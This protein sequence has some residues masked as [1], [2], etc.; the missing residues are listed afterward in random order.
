MKKLL[1]T[2]ESECIGPIRALVEKQNHRTLVLWALD[3]APTILEIF[4]R[5]FPNDKRPKEAL[6]A[7]DDWARGEIKMPV[8][9]KAIH[10]AHNA[11]SGAEGQMAAQAAARAAGHAAATVH[12]ETH[13]LSMVFYGLTA[14]VYDGEET[15]KEAIVEEK[16]AWFYERLLYWQKNEKKDK[17][18]WAPFL[19]KDAPNKE[20]LLREKM[21]KKNIKA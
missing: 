11:A 3:C 8:A 20:K 1:F 9:K 5:A 2:R 6:L 14:F 10:A 18:P 17:R 19:L 4:E 16:L 13:A 15:E 7:A 21:E 12:I